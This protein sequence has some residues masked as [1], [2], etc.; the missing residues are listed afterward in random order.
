MWFAGSAKPGPFIVRRVQWWPIQASQAQLSFKLGF[1]PIWFWYI[2]SLYI[3]E[4]NHKQQKEFIK[5]LNFE[6]LNSGVEMIYFNHLRYLYGWSECRLAHVKMGGGLRT[7][8]HSDRI[9]VNWLP[10]VINWAHWPTII[11]ENM[12][13]DK[14]YHDRIVSYTHKIRAL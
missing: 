5:S 1:F 6:P 10:C 7:L 13:Y 3:V 8:L 2:P 14:S 12:K 9:I 11:S 4:L